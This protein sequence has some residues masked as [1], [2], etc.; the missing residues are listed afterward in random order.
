M[1]DNQAAIVDQ[2]NELNVKP[3]KSVRAVPCRVSGKVSVV[4]RQ[5]R[6]PIAELLI[7]ILY[8]LH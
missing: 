4:Q 1:Y 2:I 8:S 7:E 5:R 6:V 3:G